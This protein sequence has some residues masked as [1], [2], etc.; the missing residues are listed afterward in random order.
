M[1]HGVEGLEHD[2]GPHQDLLNP[3]GVNLLRALTGTSYL[4]W[5][6]RTLAADGQEAE[7]RY[8]PVRRT[9]LFIERSL[10]RGLAWAAFEP[11]DTP[12]WLS[13]RSAIES[14]LHTLWRQGGLQGATP[15]QAYFA[16]C[17]FPATMTA[18]DIDAG[19]VVVD[20]G[21]ALLRPSEFV[22]IRLRLSA[23]QEASGGSRVTEVATAGTESMGVEPSIHTLDSLPIHPRETM[24]LRRFVAS[25]RRRPARVDPRQHIPR[26]AG[27]LLRS[28]VPR[29]RHGPGPRLLFSGPAGTGKTMAAR[30]I[31]AEL[32][33][34]LFRIDVAAIV[35]KYIGETEKNLAD[36]LRRAEAA[37]VVLLFDEA[38]ALFGRRAAGGD[39]DLRER[40]AG[41]EAEYA[42]ASLLKW[43]ASHPGIVILATEDAA[44]VR[45]AGVK[46]DAAVTLS[47]R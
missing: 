29:P 26:P 44:A 17:G 15:R 24:A 32:G 47:A 40:E 27:P 35:N 11:N 1:L 5:G 13:I 18:A 22:L 25:A 23:G 16:Q 14:F 20:V 12:L 2:L 46:I 30:V 3:V 31:A 6:A 33:L 38:D 4:V 9:A 37:E 36:V 19:V 34:P 8:V 10:T 39:T 43:L 28:T 42:L 41:R 21:V 7:W 45:R